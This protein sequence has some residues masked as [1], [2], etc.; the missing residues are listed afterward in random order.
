MAGETSGTTTGIAV[1]FFYRARYHQVMRLSLLCCL[2]MVGPL[3]AETVEAFGYKWTVPIASD[4]AIEDTAGVPALHLTV[5]RPQERP[6]RPK[7]FALADTP[8][9]NSVTISLEA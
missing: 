9:F 4:W 2:V 3:V 1:L 5:P 7:Q 8:N 6:R